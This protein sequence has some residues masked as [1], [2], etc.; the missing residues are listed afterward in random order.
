MNRSFSSVRLAGR[1]V[2]AGAVIVRGL[3]WANGLV[4]LAAPAAWFWSVPGVRFTGD[5][6]AHFVRDIGIVYLL[7]GAALL[8]GLRW[9]GQRPLLWSAAAAWL[10]AHAVLHLWEVAAGLCSPD[11]IPRDFLGVTFPALVAGALAL[12][13]WRRLA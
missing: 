4:M 13:A 6:N 1:R 9:A 2:A 12:L 5:Y 7:A 8:V 10:I 3:C 11:A